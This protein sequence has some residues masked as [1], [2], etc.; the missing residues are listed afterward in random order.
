M[1]Q[2]LRKTDGELKGRGGG[3]WGSLTPVHM[4]SELIQGLTLTLLCPKL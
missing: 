3:G 1:R 4:T 2:L